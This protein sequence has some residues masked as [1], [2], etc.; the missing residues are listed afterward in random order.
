MA[1][2]N[3]I[4]CAD[5]HLREDTPVCRTDDY[6]A[7]QQA[8]LRAIRELQFVHRCP[9]IHAGDLFD[10]WKPSP[11]LLSFAMEELPHDFYTIYGNHDLPQHNLD[12]VHR[13]GVRTLEAAEIVNVLPG[14]HWGQEP[15]PENHL[16]PGPYSALRFGGLKLM[17]WHVMT[18]LRERPYPGCPE[19]SAAKLLRQHSEADFI[20]TGH[21]HV[22]FLW[23][24]R[25]RKILNPGSMMRCKADQ[26]DHVPSVY[27]W[28]DDNSVEQVVLP[29]DEGVLTRAHLEAKDPGDPRRYEAFIENLRQEGPAISF[30]DNLE[31][32][33]SSNETSPKVRQLVWDSLEAEQ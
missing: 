15:D 33:F 18:W 19:P 27:L 26:V 9:V 12:M 11:W 17:V 10:H 31:R 6:L 13:S 29:H 23:G 25:G 30:R 14:V 1:E 4:L 7:A 28:Y 5:M 22:P 20:L 2:V 21:N 3:A 8:K 32:F 24:S 16:V